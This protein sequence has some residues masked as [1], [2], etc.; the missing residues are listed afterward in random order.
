MIE[1]TIFSTIPLEI[2]INIA[3]KLDTPSL[4]RLRATCKEINEL[5]KNSLIWKSLYRKDSTIDFACKVY[6]SN[7]SDDVD[8]FR[9]YSLEKKYRHLELESFYLEECSRMLMFAPM[10]LTVPI[11]LFGEGPKKF[12]NDGIANCLTYLTNTYTKCTKIEL[13][14]PFKQESTQQKNGKIS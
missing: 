8:F 5:A 6:M 3:R 2:F 12:C 7:V 1:T 4:L 10:A 9:L 14:N 11:W 13:E